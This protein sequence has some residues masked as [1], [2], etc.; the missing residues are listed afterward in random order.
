MSKHVWALYFKVLYCKLQETWD[1]SMKNP[2][3]FC[4][5]SGSHGGKYED[6]EPSGL[7]RRVVLYK[8]TDVSEVLTASIIALS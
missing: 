6:D 8:F 4:E 1:T 7:L 2:L 5:I 3:L